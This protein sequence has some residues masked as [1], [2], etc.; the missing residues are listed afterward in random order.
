[1]S[2]EL[3][4]LIGIFVLVILMF[5]RVPIGFAMAFV[6]IIGL[7][8]L[9]GFENALAVLSIIPYAQLTRFIPN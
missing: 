2:M 3:V 7:T 4:G 5:A 9:K 1:M 6:G 8:Y